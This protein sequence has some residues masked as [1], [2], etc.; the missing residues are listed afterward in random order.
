MNSIHY[1][2]YCETLKN[3]SAVVCCCFLLSAVWNFRENSFD[4]ASLSCY[5]FQNQWKLFLVHKYYG[6]YVKNLKKS[7]DDHATFTLCC[8]GFICAN[9]FNF[10]RHHLY[11]HWICYEGVYH[12]VQMDSINSMKKN[13]GICMCCLW[14]QSEVAW[15]HTLNHSTVMSVLKLRHQPTKDVTCFPY[16]SSY[17]TIIRY[18]KTFINR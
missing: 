15:Q 6:S 8:G 11:N 18:H 9:T 1:S 5:F 7:N 4:F 2:I 17:N 12:N 14:D 10:T 3:F 16:L 13:F